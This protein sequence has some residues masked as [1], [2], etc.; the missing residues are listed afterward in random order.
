MA[1]VLSQLGLTP[2]PDSLQSRTNYNT[3]GEVV[4]ELRVFGALER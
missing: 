3:R 4:G 2:Q 1:S